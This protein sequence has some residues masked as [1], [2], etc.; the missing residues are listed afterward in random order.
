MLIDDGLDPRVFC[1]VVESREIVECVEPQP[2]GLLVGR[3]GGI[4]PAVA[5]ASSEPGVDAAGDIEG[6]GALRHHPLGDQAQRREL[7]GVERG[8]V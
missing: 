5:R 4:A 1:L 2:V 8:G 6:G 3:Q 7:R